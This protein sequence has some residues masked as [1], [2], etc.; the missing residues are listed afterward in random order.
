MKDG[1]ESIDNFL[2]E[3]AALKVRLAAVLI[4]A[5]AAT[6]QYGGTGKLANWQAVARWH[7]SAAALGR[8]PLILAGGLTPSNV[9]DAISAV[10]PHAVDT[11]SGVESALGI[12]DARL[13]RAFVAAAK[14]AFAGA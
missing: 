1:G 10:G 11:A 4:D 14:R 7:S 2:A 8:P 13:V 12:K 6:G 3:C 5:D 9:A